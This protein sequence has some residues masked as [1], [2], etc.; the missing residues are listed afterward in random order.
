MKHTASWLLLVLM[1]SVGLA[2]CGKSKQDD[3][4]PMT[5]EQMTGGDYSQMP[6]EAKA[7]MEAAKAKSSGPPANINKGGK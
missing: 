7:A 2:G 4:G 6:P 3:A 1:L 5:K